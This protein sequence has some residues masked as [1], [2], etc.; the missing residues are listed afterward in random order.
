MYICNSEGAWKLRTDLLLVPCMCGQGRKGAT[1]LRGSPRNVD[2]TSAIGTLLAGFE[3][4]SGHGDKGCVYIS[5]RVPNVSLQVLSCIFGA[6]VESLG[7]IV[8]F[9]YAPH[10]ILKND[11]LRTPFQP[12]QALQGR[13]TAMLGKY[14]LPPHKVNSLPE[15]PLHVL[16]NLVI[17]WHGGAGKKRLNRNI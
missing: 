10:I 2:G 3:G 5:C 12:S 1:N 11:S 7:Y 14:K 8:A 4:V 9:Q 13:P 17:P 15:L 6:S 16:L